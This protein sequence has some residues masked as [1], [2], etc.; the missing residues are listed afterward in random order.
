MQYTEARERYS[1]AKAEQRRLH[2]E[3]VQI[4]ERNKPI[5]DFK[6]YARPYLPPVLH[7]Y[8]CAQETR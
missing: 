6:K 1:T 2:E 7:S 3:V 4:K 5:L 8:L